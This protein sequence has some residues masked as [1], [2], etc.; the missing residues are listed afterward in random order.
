M[1]FF[2]TEC[3]SCGSALRLSSEY[4]GQE[5][6]CGRCGTVFVA[7]PTNEPR[8]AD[9]P[10]LREFDDEPDE[11][12]DDRP[13]RRSPPAGGSGGTAVTALVLGILAAVAWPCPPAGLVL[14]GVAVLTGGAGLSSRSRPAAV[15]GIVLGLVGVILS[16]GCG[17]LYGVAIQQE[18]R[19]NKLEPGGNHPPFVH[20]AD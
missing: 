11:R 3:P 7:A 17:V 9:P 12:Y 19:A 6:R 20:E 5:A 8:R 15:T 2:T 4:E 16:L 14:G 18:N 13:I 1:S 10:P